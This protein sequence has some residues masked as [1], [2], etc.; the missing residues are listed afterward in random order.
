M[1]ISQLITIAPLSQGGAADGSKTTVLDAASI[2]TAVS[3]KKAKATKAA[4]LAAKEEDSMRKSLAFATSQRER[5]TEK[6]VFVTPLRK[7]AVD[8]PKTTPAVKIGQYVEVKDNLGRFG[9][10]RHGG[11]GQVIAVSGVGGKTVV[12]VS[13]LI[14]GHKEHDIPMEDYTQIVN[15]TLA[16]PGERAAKGRRPPP[17]QQQLAVKEEHPLLHLSF[18]AAMKAAARTGRKEG[19]R[20]EMAFGAGRPKRFSQAERQQAIVEYKEL[21]ANETKHAKRNSKSGGQFVART[22]IHS[23]YV[24]GDG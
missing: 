19:W 7:P 16:H 5:S 1:P 8:D 4:K 20:R 21:L 14:G 17:S 12:S 3:T 23:A 9:P 18:E 6:H 13:Y 11:K 24:N 15:P 2:K 22:T 10:A